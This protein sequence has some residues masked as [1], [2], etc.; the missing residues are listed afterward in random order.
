MEI[1][2]QFLD[3]VI[4]GDARQVLAQ[5]KQ[6]EPF[7][8]LIITSPPYGDLVDYNAKGQLGFGQT[9]EA[10]IKDINRIMRQ[11]FDLLKTTGSLW[12]VLDAWR[13]DEKYRLLPFEVARNAQIV[14]WSLQDIIIWDKQHTLPYYRHGQFQPVYEYILLLTKGP[15]FKFYRDRIRDVDGLSMWWVDFPERFNPLGKSPTNIWTI[16]IRPQGAWRGRARPWHHY[17]PFPTELVARIIELTTDP[18]DIVLDP[19]AGSCTVPATAKAMDRHYVGVEINAKFIRQF[20]KTVQEEVEVEWRMIQAKR[21]AMLGLNGSFPALILKLRALKFARKASSVLESQIKKMRRSHK[22]KLKLCICIVQIPDHFDA[23]ESLALSLYFLVSGSK[24]DFDRTV[25][26]VQQS[27]TTF[28]LSQYRIKASIFGF[29]QRHRLSR[30]LGLNR[31]LYLYPR[32]KVRS[33]LECRYTDT[34][35][36]GEFWTTVDRVLPIL[37]NVKVDVTWMADS[38]GESVLKREKVESVR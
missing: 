33:Y 4:H 21:H 15:E 5:I 19:F 7:I 38:Y 10:Y 37:S 22:L 3:K 34:W 1:P 8:D 12:L 30:S 28:P 18:G 6:P 23:D 32:T 29:N 13:E 20:H 26:E 31:R 35:L 16:P 27:L 36:S 2:E 14:G 11:C 9:W 24:S 25:F 17:C